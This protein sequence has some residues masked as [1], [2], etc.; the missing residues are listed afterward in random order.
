MSQAAWIL[1]EAFDAVFPVGGFASEAASAAVSRFCSAAGSFAARLA[2]PQQI[3]LRASHV[4]GFRKIRFPTLGSHGSKRSH[5]IC[6][7]EKFDFEFPELWRR[8]TTPG[9]LE[10]NRLH[11][12]PPFIS[13]FLELRAIPAVTSSSRGAQSSSNSCRCSMAS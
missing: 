12:A 13:D 4:F 9:E 1:A 6:T 3:R 11:P 5:I 7:N 2:G 8:G 10:A